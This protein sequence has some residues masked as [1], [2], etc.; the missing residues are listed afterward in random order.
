VVARV[1][2]LALADRLGL[3][4]L[5]G[6]AGA[7]MGD[8]AEETVVAVIWA[9]QA[10]VVCRRQ[11]GPPAR[12][13][14]VEVPATLAR[15]GMAEFL[16]VAAQPPRVERMAAMAGV[17]LQAAESLAVEEPAVQAV[18]L[19]AVAGWKMEAARAQ[20][21]RIRPAGQMHKVAI[22]EAGRV[23]ATPPRV[24][25]RAQSEAMPDIPLLDRQRCC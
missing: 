23:P 14:Q 8:S 2:R 11:V 4:V 21:A 24:V 1:A 5:R 22:P 10:A 9:R 19:Q 6:L 18:R 25:A 3:A 17:R 13:E 7:G 16:A 12:R 15:R 20:G